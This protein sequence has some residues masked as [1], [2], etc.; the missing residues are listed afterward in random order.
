MAALILLF[1]LTGMSAVGLSAGE[2]AHVAVASGGIVVTAED[3]GVT[4]MMLRV[5][6]PG[7]ELV[8]EQSS[9][10][11]PISWSPADAF[12]DGTYTWEARTGTAGR[13]RTREGGEASGT[14]TRPWR[15]SGAV[16]VEGGAI[17]LPSESEELGLLEGILSGATRALATCMD[18]MATPAYAD[19]Q[20]LDDLIVDGSLAVGQD[21]VNGEAFGFDTLRLKENN[22]RIHFQ[23]TSNSA[24]F[25]SNDWRITINDSGNGGGNYFSVDDATYGSVPFKIEAGAPSS[26]LYV[27]SWGRIGLGTATPEMALHIVNGETPGLRLDQDGTGGWTPQ[28]WDVAGNESHFFIRD[29]T[30]SESI[31]FKIEP[32]TPTDTLALAGSGYVGIGTTQPTAKL[33]VE[34]DAFVKGNLEVGSSRELKENI[35]ALGAGEA[36]ATLKELQPVRYNYK[37]EPGEETIGFIAED[38][39]DLVATNSRKSLNPMDMVAVLARVTQEQQKIIEDLSQRIADLEKEQGAASGGSRQ[40]RTL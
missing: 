37:T 6:G 11:D 36:M 15:K 14:R 22:L 39:P 34:G 33:H 2:G 32:A 8:S 27:E 16:S 40:G 19:Q 29:V 20:I 24:S 30:N 5:V 23:D 4:Y 18:F 28:V 10:G 21:A 12:Q 31:P 9:G 1:V 35:H 25:P 17:V 3:A 38:V 7:G 26:S 13:N